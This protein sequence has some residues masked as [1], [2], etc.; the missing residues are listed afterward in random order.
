MATLIKLKAV[1]HF[2]LT[3]TNLERSVAFYTD[4]L[5]FEVLMV[6]GPKTILSNGQIILALNEAPDPTQRPENDRF[7]EH[8]AGLD[9]ISFS[10]ASRADLEAAAQLFDQKGISRGTINDLA[11]AGLPIYVMAFRDPDN[12]QLELTVPH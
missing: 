5:N 7:S 6:L 9:H 3:V 8:R 11:H 2:A 12:I 10:V 1:H 4:I